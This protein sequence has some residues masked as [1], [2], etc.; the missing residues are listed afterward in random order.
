MLHTVLAILPQKYEPSGVHKKLAKLA[1]YHSYLEF[2][3]L[4]NTAGTFFEDFKYSLYLWKISINSQRNSEYINREVTGVTLLHI[5]GMLQQWF[6]CLITGMIHFWRVLELFL[7][8]KTFAGKQY[9]DLQ[10]IYAK[11]IMKLVHNS[12]GLS[13]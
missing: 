6:Y 10:L 11:G 1:K 12:L 4:D 3:L 2:I 7:S 9:N 5:A 8:F 13:V